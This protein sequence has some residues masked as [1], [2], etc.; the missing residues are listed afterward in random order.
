MSFT[1]P[2]GSDEERKS[3]IIW[4]GKWFDVTPYLTHYAYGYHTGADLNLNYPHWDGDAHSAVYAMGDGVVTYAQLY[5]RKVWGNLIIIDHG[6]VDGK[7]LFSRYAH[8]EN[9]QVA[10]GQSV[11]GICAWYSGP[12]NGFGGPPIGPIV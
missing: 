12:S 3:G 8:V 7:P 4:P 6:I 10:A 5:S 11:I 2:I 9:I 1:A